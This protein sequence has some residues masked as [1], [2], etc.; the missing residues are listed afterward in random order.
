MT[1]LKT[2]DLISSIGNMHAYNEKMIQI[3]G[4]DI[5]GVAA[6]ALGLEEKLVVQRLKQCSVG[7]IPI[8]S[9]EGIISGFSRL[10]YEIAGFLGCKAQILSPD[11]EG[12]AEAK[13][14]NCEIILWSDD[15]TYLA[16][17]LLHPF[18]AE[19]GWATGLGYAFALD[20]MAS[21]CQY[22]KKVL[23]L[24]AGP[25]GRSASYALSHAGYMVVLCDKDFEKAQNYAK[26][27]PRCAAVDM[28]TIADYSP[29][30]CLLDATPADTRYSEKYLAKNPCISAP[31][32]PCPWEEK[33]EYSAHLWHDPLQ[34]GTVIMLVSAI[35]R[36]TN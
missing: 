3:L 26:T 25:V 17:N 35:M 29:Y 2:E 23:V 8:S 14:H 10:L 16:E 6:Y 24:G 18:Q 36:K 32:V 30:Y 28:E 5:Y 12:F 20:L 19:N 15:D 11:K 13:A 27:L 1:R 22:E 34:L 31:C 21:R 7:I 9:G 4:R 33:K